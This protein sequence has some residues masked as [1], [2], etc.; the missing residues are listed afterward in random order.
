MNKN[1]DDFE[2]LSNEEIAELAK[3]L[4][5][6]MGVDW[7]GDPTIL[8]YWFLPKFLIQLNSLVTDE[9]LRKYHEWICEN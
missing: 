8:P 9:T 6:E 5:K 4:A 2:G 1:F 7:D 3:D